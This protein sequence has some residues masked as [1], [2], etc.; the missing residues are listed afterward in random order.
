MYK[1]ELHIHTKECDKVA[2]VGGA[3]IVNLYKNE[4]YDGVVVTDH[5]FSLFFDW[6][7]NEMDVT[8][9]TKIV[10]RYLKGYYAA[11]NEGEK[12]GITVLCGTEVRFDNCINDYLVYGLEEQDF[13]KLPLLNKLKDVSELVDILPDYSV[14]VQA[15]PFRNRMV[16]DDPSPL[17]GIEGYNGGTERF[18]NDMAK[19]F[20]RLYNKPLTSGSDFHNAN[21]LAKGGIATEKRICTAQDLVSVLRSGEYSLIQDKEISC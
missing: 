2:Q 12:V 15:H 17:F 11:K 9:H 20:A 1:Y 21:H 6:F 10:D 14:V 19:Y 8:D 3:E 7:K 13:Y 16:V 4:G 18:R 5:Y